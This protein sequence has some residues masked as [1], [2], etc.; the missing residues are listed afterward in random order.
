MNRVVVPATR[1]HRAILRN[2]FELYAHDFSEMTGADVDEQGAFTPRDFLAGWW[3]RHAGAFH[4]F[5]LQIDA[6]WAGF[7]FVEVGSYVAPDSHRHWLMEEFFVLR[8]FRRQGHGRWF[9]RELIARFP[10]A[11]EIGQI[12]ENIAATDFWR[13]VLR[14]DLRVQFEEQVVDNARWQGPVQVFDSIARRL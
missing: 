13:R 11:W 1:A 2:L 8:K 4:P 6:V 9:A 3:D 10:G 14:D 5:L 7:A 12:P